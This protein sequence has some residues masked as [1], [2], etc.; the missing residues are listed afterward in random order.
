[1]KGLSRTFANLAVGAGRAF[2]LASSIQGYYNHSR[3]RAKSY[4]G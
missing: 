1:M 4:H 3:S 2:F